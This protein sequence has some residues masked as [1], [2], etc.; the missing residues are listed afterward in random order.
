MTEVS[1]PS[2]VVEKLT[3]KLEE[4]SALSDECLQELKSLLLDDFSDA[5]ILKILEKEACNEDKES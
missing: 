2:Q 3:E 5:D 4:K 1:I